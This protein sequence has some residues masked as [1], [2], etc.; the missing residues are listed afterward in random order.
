MTQSPL[1]QNPA[2]KELVRLFL[3]ASGLVVKLTHLIEHNDVPNAQN[4]LDA[5]HD[6]MERNQLYAECLGV[7][8]PK[9]LSNDD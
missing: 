7:I 4:H 1:M 9:G 5:A 6:F 3:E 2:N 8:M